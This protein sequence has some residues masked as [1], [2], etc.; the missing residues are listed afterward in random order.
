MDSQLIRKN[1]QKHYKHDLSMIVVTI[2]F[3]SFKKLIN[4]RT[5]S[6]SLNLFFWKFNILTDLRQHH[7]QFGGIKD[8]TIQSILCQSQSLTL[9]I[10]GINS[11]NSP[12]SLTLQIGGINSL[13]SQFS[14]ALQIGGI[15]S[16]NNPFNQAPQI[17]G[18]H[19]LLNSKIVVNKTI[20]VE[21]SK[22]FIFRPCDN[23]CS[24]VPCTVIWVINK[25]LTVT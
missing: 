2:L 16:L 13:N 3:V 21:V 1:D 17:G 23:T 20:Y 10:G 4:W 22:L 24:C 6:I 9:Q 19:N 14:L 8:Q 15:N 5:M 12:F 25:N 11:L 7:P 18:N